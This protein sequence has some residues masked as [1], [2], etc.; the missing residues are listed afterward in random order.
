MR[1]ALWPGSLADHDVEIE[2][3]FARPDSRMRTLVAE[4][5]GRLI[6]FLELDQR[7]YAPGC[8]SSPVPFIEGWYVDPAARRRGVGRALV[9]AAEEWARAA[10][11][12]EMGSDAEI[13]NA[14]SLAAH[15]ALGYVE[16]ERIVCF[17]RA[18]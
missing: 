13:E 8:A 16:I 6:G 15:Q 4:D 18:L 11:F 2:R 14:D 1:T 3:F 7:K 12:I 17:R 10:G 9:R 5:E